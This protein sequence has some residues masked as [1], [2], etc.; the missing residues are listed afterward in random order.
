MN[1]GI[2]ETQATAGPCVEHKGKKNWEQTK[3]QK[4]SVWGER[5]WEKRAQ[6]ISL[7]MFVYGCFKVRN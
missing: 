7:A 6:G 3:Q 2:S 1:E 4:I 5:V